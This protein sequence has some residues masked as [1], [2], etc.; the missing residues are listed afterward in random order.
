[1]APNSFRWASMSKEELLPSTKPA[2][3]PAPLNCG[4]N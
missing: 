1:M 2:A 4:W 3:P